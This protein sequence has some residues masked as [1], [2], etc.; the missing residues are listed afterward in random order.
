MGVLNSGWSLEVVGG[1]GVRL[2][3]QTVA[4]W[5]ERPPNVPQA[6]SYS[7]CI[8]LVALCSL[9]FTHR[10]LLPFCRSQL[11]NTDR[12][13]SCTELWGGINRRFLWATTMSSNDMEHT[14][15]PVEV[16]LECMLAVLQ[17]EVDKNDGTKEATSSN[18]LD[19]TLDTASP[20]VRSV[21]SADAGATAKGWECLHQLQDDKSRNVRWA[22]TSNQSLRASRNSTPHTLDSG[23]GTQMTVHGRNTRRCMNDRRTPW[24]AEGLYR[25]AI[26]PGD[27]KIFATFWNVLQRYAKKIFF[28]NV[29]GTLDKMNR[30]LGH[31]CAHIG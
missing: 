24:M 28:T 2:K 13:R 27:G 14:D 10:S 5:S 20:W 31:L 23:R 12:D 16:D 3:T 19:P 21:R 17:N 18:L 25:N 11:S 6:S 22:L 9:V 7:P 15:E 1:G 30:A 29:V 4:Q 26:R 8:V